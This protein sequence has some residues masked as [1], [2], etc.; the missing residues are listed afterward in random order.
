M[1]FLKAVRDFTMKINHQRVLDK[2]RF[3][4]L[5]YYEIL[6]E[7]TVLSD[8]IPCICILLSGS[9]RLRFMIQKLKVLIILS[10]AVYPYCDANEQ[11]N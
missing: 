4:L 1:Y 9:P 7:G 6:R 8:Q 2:V 3:T 10:L 11:I 5:L